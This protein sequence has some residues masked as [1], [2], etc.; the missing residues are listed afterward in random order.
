VR[1]G[2]LRAFAVEWDHSLLK[3]QIYGV[4]NYGAAV[5]FFLAFY[6]RRDRPFRSRVLHFLG[7][8]SYPLYVIHPLVGYVGLALALRAGFTP[9][10]S[11]AIVVP[12]IFCAAYALHRIVENPSIVL[13][14]YLVRRAGDAEAS[15][16]LSGPNE[17]VTINGA[18]SIARDYA[19]RIW[20]TRYFWTHLVAADLRAK[21]RRSSL[22]LLWAIIHPLALTGLLSLVM[23]RVFGSPIV[24]YA[25]FIFSGLILWNL[26]SALS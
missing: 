1:D 17:P 10:V 9:I 7:N 8:I 23:S 12:L 14:H 26:S 13:G 15:N 16:P 21:Y 11:L 5:A 24:E 4:A 22:G 20:A 3:A 2:A 25:P 19:R 18:T 6:L